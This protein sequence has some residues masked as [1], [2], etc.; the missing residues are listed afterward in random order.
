MNSEIELYAETSHGAGNLRELAS[1]CFRHQRLILFT[2]CFVF[3]AF[4]LYVC[5]VPRTYQAE[6]EILVKRGRAI[7]GNPGQ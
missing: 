3:A 5:V 6:T 1:V 2:L 7:C 4:I